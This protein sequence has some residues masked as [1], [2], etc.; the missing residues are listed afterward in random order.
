VEPTSTPSNGTLIFSLSTEDGGEVPPSATICLG[1]LCQ[2]ADQFRVAA[3]AG[4]LFTFSVPSGSYALTVHDAVPYADLATTISVADGETLTVPLVLTLA[5]T[6]TPGPME[7]ISPTAAAVSPTA[8][9]APITN[10]PNTGGPSGA[11]GDP[12]NTALAALG[13]ALVLLL[14]SLILRK[15][16]GLR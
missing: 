9:A 5:P 7:P 12:W 3:D 15:R 13:L 4:A 10:L 2:T 6:P 8:S 11:S 1:I 14:S 16:R